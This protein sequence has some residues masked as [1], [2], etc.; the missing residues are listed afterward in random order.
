MIEYL[1]VSPNHSRDWH[2]YDFI[3]RDQDAWL[4]WRWPTPAREPIRERV[5]R[6][7]A[8]LAGNVASP[9]PDWQPDRAASRP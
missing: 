6:L 8:R 7:L 3:H 1:R 2:N 9:P 4:A 5:I